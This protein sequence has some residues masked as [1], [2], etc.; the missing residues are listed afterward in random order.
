[1]EWLKS[2]IPHG[3]FKKNTV[4]FASIY[5]QMLKKIGFLLLALFLAFRSY[6]QVAGLVQTTTLDL[7][8]FESALVSFLLALYLTGVFAFPG[9]VFATN[10][11]LPDAYYRIRHPERLKAAYRGLG[12]AFFKRFLLITF[13]GKE[14]HRRRYFDGTK[15]GIANFDYQ[16]RQSEFGH[17]GA[18]I[19]LGVVSALLL[20]H[21]YTLIFSLR[22]F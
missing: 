17:L 15:T 7:S 22:P 20:F 9:F 19:V 18:F 10:K 4:L 16:T 14:K 1:M 13:W 11:L 2:N 21:G 12:G 6:E 8:F 3:D 5:I